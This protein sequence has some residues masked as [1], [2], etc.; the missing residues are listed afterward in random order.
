MLKRNQSYAFLYL[1]AF[2]VDSVRS[3][4]RTVRYFNSHEKISTKNENCSKNVDEPTR[5]TI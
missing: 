3:H 2:H 1:L 5:I 4:A